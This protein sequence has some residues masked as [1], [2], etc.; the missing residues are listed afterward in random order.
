MEYRRSPIWPFPNTKEEIRRQLLKIFPEH[1]RSIHG[2]LNFIFS[3]LKTNHLKRPQSTKEMSQILW[4]TG[5]IT[6]I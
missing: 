4:D 1:A 5:N 2:L 3:C 6:E